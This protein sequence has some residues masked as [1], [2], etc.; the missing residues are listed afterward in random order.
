MCLY[1]INKIKKKSLNIVCVEVGIFVENFMSKK[2]FLKYLQNRDV[3][4]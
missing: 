2:K 1:I 3:L 4:P